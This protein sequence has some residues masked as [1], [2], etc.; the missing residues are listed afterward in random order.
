MLFGGLSEQEVKSITKILDKE[1]VQF[2]VAIDGEVIGA[3]KESME[4][5][6]RH[7]HGA[8]ISTHILT[9]EI[10]DQS[11]A[12]ISDSSKDDL[13]VFGITDIAPSFEETIEEVVYKLENKEKKPLF[14]EKW[15]YRLIF[16]VVVFL[17]V[18]LTIAISQGDYF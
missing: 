6:L 14:F 15:G 3:N 1:N 11:F 8:N 17:M 12:G 18:S 7:Y 10:E 5:N 2:K 9:I 13:L 4:Q 16:T